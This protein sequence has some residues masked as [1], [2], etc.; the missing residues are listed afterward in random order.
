MVEEEDVGARGGDTEHAY[1]N[2]QDLDNEVANHSAMEACCA[3]REV[4]R[5]PVSVREDT[6]R[7]GTTREEH[8]GSTQPPGRRSQTHDGFRRQRPILLQSEPCRSHAE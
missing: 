2:A 3:L 5:Q 8:T 7:D 4:L 1:I 6:I